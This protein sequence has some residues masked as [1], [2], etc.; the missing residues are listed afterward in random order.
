MVITLGAVDFIPHN[1]PP[2]T[3]RLSG[4]GG[5][6][7][8]NP[9][10]PGAGGGWVYTPPL[11]TDKKYLAETKWQNIRPGQDLISREISPN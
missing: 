3:P 4:G 11:P 2:P 1:P 5:A 8:T 7:F 9:S 6:E 10:D